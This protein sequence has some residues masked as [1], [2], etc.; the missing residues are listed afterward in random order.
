MTVSGGI[1]PS[2]QPR[3]DAVQAAVR[4]G[5]GAILTLRTRLERLSR[6]GREIARIAP[7]L[8]NAAAT[9]GI[10]AVACAT[11]AAGAIV[12]SMSSVSVSLEVSVSISASASVSSR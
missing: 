5:L 12:D 7:E 1:D 6:S 10:G 9:V 2:M 3:V 8:P 11:S 4:E